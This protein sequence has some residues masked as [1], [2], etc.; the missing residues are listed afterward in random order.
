MV[1]ALL[2]AT[3]SLAA[4]TSGPTGA[5]FD[6]CS[7]FLSIRAS[8]PERDVHAQWASGLIVGR[9]S[10]SH[11]Y[12]P[13]DLSLAEVAAQLTTRCTQ[14]PKQSVLLA[15]LAIAADYQHRK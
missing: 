9:L 15:A 13:E 1:A 6:S 2:V 10:A 3:D 4:G 12:V 8:T 14:D 5:G 7:D 11:H